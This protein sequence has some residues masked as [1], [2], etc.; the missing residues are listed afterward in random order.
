MALTESSSILAV[1]FG[2]AE[3]EIDVGAGDD[4]ETTGVGV[5]RDTTAVDPS[6]SFATPSVQDVSINTN[7]NIPREIT[8]FI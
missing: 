5:S 8:F 6:A 7:S 4:E 3:E 2:C 1:S